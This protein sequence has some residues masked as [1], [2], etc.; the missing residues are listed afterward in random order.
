MGFSRN[1]NSTGYVSVWHQN[2]RIQASTISHS[3]IIFHEPGDRYREY[4]ILRVRVLLTQVVNMDTTMAGR[5]SRLVEIEYLP[6]RNISGRVITHIPIHTISGQSIRELTY[7]LQLL[8]TICISL[9]YMRP[10]IMRE[11]RYSNWDSLLLVSSKKREA[12]KLKIPIK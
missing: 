4:L 7:F 8:H 1:E 10:V 11:S 3:R 6:L 5:M 2:L 9:I 12:Q